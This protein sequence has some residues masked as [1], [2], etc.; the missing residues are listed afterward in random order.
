MM[1][2]TSK[3]ILSV[4]ALSF[5]LM[6]CE[7]SQAAT[8]NPTGATAQAATAQPKATKIVFVGK[9]NACDCTRKSIDAGWAALQK[10]L[11]TPAK[12]PVQELK[13]DTES[14]KVAPYRKQKPMMALP[15]IYFVDGKE[16]VMELLQGE[17][18]E[19]QIAEVLKR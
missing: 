7:R 18:T 5:S 4:L 13:I 19:A 14:D 10:A 12:L 3:T 2:A 8:A 17:V 11:G 1:T 6:G 9:Q 15:A 16:A